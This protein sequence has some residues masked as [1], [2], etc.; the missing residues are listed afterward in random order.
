MRRKVFRRSGVSSSPFMAKSK[1]P[2]SSPESRLGKAYCL[3]SIGRPISRL[4]GLDQIDLEADVLAGVF[5]V[6]GNVRRPAFGIGGPN[7]RRQLPRP[8]TAGR[9]R[10]KVPTGPASRPVE[11]RPGAAFEEIP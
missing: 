1:S 8:G 7:E 11:R 6:H 3:N 10:P 2:R 4:Q 9:F 5:G